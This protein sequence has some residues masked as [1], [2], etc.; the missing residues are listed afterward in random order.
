MEDTVIHKIYRLYGAGMSYYGSTHQPL[1]E[2]K[3]NHKSHHKNKRVCCASKLIMDACEDWDLE[4]VETLPANSSK[5]EVLTREKWWVQN[6]ECVNKNTPIQTAEELKEYKRVWAENARRKK[7][8]PVKETDPE[9]IKENEKTH[10]KEYLKN[11]PQEVKEER[12]KMRRENRKELTEEQKKQARE[13]AREQREKQKA[14]QIPRKE[15][16]ED[17]R[18]KQNLKSKEK[19]TNKTDEEKAEIIKRN[20]ETRKNLTPEEKERRL[21]M[22]RENRKK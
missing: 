10:R 4:I 6:N 8:I 1:Y 16:T 13:R 15:L 3:A 5:E 22:R 12:L 2:R 20:C 18:T 19:Y 21:K 17:Q 9:K 11:L 7:G 14:E